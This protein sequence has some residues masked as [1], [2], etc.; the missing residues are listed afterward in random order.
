MS[1]INEKDLEMATGGYNFSEDPYEVLAAQEGYSRHE[2]F[3]GK[4]CP[5]YLSNGSSFTHTGCLYCEHM[6][7]ARDRAAVLFCKI[8]L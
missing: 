1:E 6:T 2:A 5:G 7:V 3:D 4:N 8:G